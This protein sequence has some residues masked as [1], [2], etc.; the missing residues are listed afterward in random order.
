VLVTPAVLV[1]VALVTGELAAKGLV[2]AE[3]ARVSVVETKGAVRAIGVRV[4]AGDIADGHAMSDISAAYTDGIRAAVGVDGAALLAEAAG[5]RRF[6]KAREVAAATGDGPE[7]AKGVWSRAVRVP[8]AFVFS[9]RYVALPAVQPRVPARVGRIAG[10]FRNS[11]L[12][13]TGQ[14]TR[15]GLFFRPMRV[16]LRASEEPRILTREE[17]LGGRTR[18]RRAEGIGQARVS[19]DATVGLRE[20]IGMRIGCRTTRARLYRETK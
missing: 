7:L 2:L 10:D 18:E 8:R 14:A 9:E 19:R 3:A 11:N 12:D 17:R 5:L 16:A 15:T 20:P 13:V 6:G 4:A 1:G